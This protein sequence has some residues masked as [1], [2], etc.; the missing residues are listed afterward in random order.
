MREHFTVIPGKPRR[1]DSKPAVPESGSA[2]DSNFRER[3]WSSSP[4]A[5]SGNHA[6]YV[7]FGFGYVDYNDIDYYGLYVRCVR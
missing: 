7:Y 3:D 4:V 2:G 6:W 5:G 1:H